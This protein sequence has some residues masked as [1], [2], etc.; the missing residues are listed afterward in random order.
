MSTTVKP[1]LYKNKKKQKTILF[2]ICKIFN[3]KNK[4]T[5]IN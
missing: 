4:K 2:V 1:V 5:L 3:N